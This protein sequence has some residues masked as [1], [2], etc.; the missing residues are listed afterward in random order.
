L[1]A[2][3]PTIKAWME[4]TGKRLDPPQVVVDNVQEQIAPNIFINNF[5]SRT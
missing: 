2:Q 3:N 1:T 5:G 4:E